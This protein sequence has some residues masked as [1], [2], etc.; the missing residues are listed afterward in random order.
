MFAPITQARHPRAISR[1]ELKSIISKCYSPTDQQVEVSDRSDSSV[2]ET[3][4]QAIH[5]SYSEI[6]RHHAD[7]CVKSSHAILVCGTTFIMS[8]A[9]AQLGIDEP[10]DAE[11][12]RFEYKGEL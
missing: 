2:G 11:T 3:I 9:R 5:D 12:L 8:E 1:M 4:H 7:G 6:M 10:R